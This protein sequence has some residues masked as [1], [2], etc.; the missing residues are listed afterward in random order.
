MNSGRPYFLRPQEYK[1]L[2]ELYVKKG[3]WTIKN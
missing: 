2:G 1:G 3:K